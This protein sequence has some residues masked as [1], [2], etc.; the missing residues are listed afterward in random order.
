MNATRDNKEPC[1]ADKQWQTMVITRV[2]NP[3]INVEGRS[4][5]KDGSK[6]SN[7]ENTERTKYYRICD[8]RV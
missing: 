2:Q 7:L 6:K 5:K 4:Q 8:S 3:L 1:N